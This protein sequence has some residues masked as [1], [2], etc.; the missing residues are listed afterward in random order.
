MKKGLI[1]VLLAG[2]LL[3]SC[4]QNTE[5]PVEG[6]EVKTPATPVVEVEAVDAEGNEAE[7]VIEG[8]TTT[9]EVDAEAVVD[10]VEAAVEAGEGEKEAEADVEIE[11]K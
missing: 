11:V 5:T 6:G 1:A 3:A 8:N 10:A 9:P 2:A 4:G 7:V